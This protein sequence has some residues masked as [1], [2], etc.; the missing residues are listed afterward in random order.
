[1]VKDISLNNQIKNVMRLSVPAI[2][3]QVASIVMQY[4]DSAMVGALGEEASAAIGL[5][6]SSTW[7]LGGVISA[8]AIGFA[9]QVAHLF[10]ANKKK[11]ARNVLMHGII[12]STIISLVLTI[13]CMLIAEPLPVWLNGDESILDDAT[14]YFLA[15]VLS[16]PFLMSMNL[17]SNV[18]QCSGNMV[19][20]SILNAIMCLLDVVFN[21]IFIP[22]YGVLGAG[23]GTALSVVVVSI[24]SFV[25]CAFMNKNLKLRK[26]DNYKL[27]KDILKSALKIGTPIAI[28]QIAFCGAMVV[29]TVIITTSIVGPLGNASV[30]AHSFAITAES[31]CY[32]P[33][34][35]VASA[36]TTLVGQ[37]IGR[38]NNKLAKRYGTISIILGTLLMTLMAVIMYIACPLVFKMLTPSVTVQEISK[39]ILRIG[40]LAE[41]LYAVSIVATGALRGAEDTFVPSLLNIISI[42]CVRIV[43][44]IIL[45]PKYGIDGVWIAMATELSFRGIV[46]LIRNVTTKYYDRTKTLKLNEE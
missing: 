28:E 16:M 41:P 32:M 7:V 42:W 11:D 8:I 36:A 40:L 4:I 46:L 19:I 35:G 37:E 5:V 29:T 6:I 1:M 44:Q 14:K 20:P 18:L 25:I 12:V 26:D 24:V 3:T 21:A 34:F 10:G 23:I 13:G 39:R 31:L 45:T 38:R 2:L 17:T 43:L 30:A 33:A 9:V 15:Y 27:N 22:K